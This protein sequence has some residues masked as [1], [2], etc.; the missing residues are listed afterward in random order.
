MSQENVDRLRRGHEGFSRGDLSAVKDTLAEDVDWGTTG[1]FPGLAAVY[2]GP[3]A[4][5]RW[6]ASVRSAWEWFE[7]SLAEVLEADE[8][9]VVVAERL[10]GR[11]RESGAE[12]EMSA[13]AAYWFSEG[14]IIK[15][16]A[17]TERTEALKAAGLSE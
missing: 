4:F 2:R 7:V 13:F 12:V 8:S 17:F 14:K 3:G 15:R 10:R 9:V 16:R 5:Q 1:S 6:M 11:G